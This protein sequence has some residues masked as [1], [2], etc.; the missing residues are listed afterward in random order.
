MQVTSPQGRVLH[1]LGDE[2]LLTESRSAEFLARFDSDPRIAT[3][4]LMAVPDS[5]PE[6][7]E[8]RWLR[9][10]APAGALVLVADDLT[11]LIGPFDLEDSGTW[12][13]WFTEASNQGM[14]HDWWVTSDSDIATSGILLSTASTDEVEFFDLSSSHAQFMS[15]MAQLD[16]LTITVDGSWLG[17]IESGAQVMTIAAINALARRPDV[18]EIRLVGMDEVPDY[19]QS[20]SLSGKVLLFTTDQKVPRS[21]IMWYPHQIYSA[22]EGYDQARL[23]AN[24]IVVTYLDLIQYD[25]PVY[26]KTHAGHLAYRALQRRI[27]LSAD[28]VSTIS[29]DVA[30]RLHDEVPE[31]DPA[32]IHATVLGLDHVMDQGSLETLPRGGLTSLKILLKR[33][34]QD[35]AS[36]PFILVL[37][38]SFL[39]KN[40]DFA[41]RAWQQVLAK[42]I[43][44]DLVMAGSLVTDDAGDRLASEQHTEDLSDASLGE[45]FLVGWNV[46]AASRLWLLANAAVVLYP[47]SAEGFGLPPY[48]AAA[49]GSPASFTDFGP[50]KEVSGVAGLPANW[51][52]EEYARDLV[53]LL[54]DP[55]AAQERTN[56]LQEA[57]ARHTWDGF[58]DELVN[59]FGRVA[60]MPVAPAGAL[61]GHSS[62]VVHDAVS[63]LFSTNVPGRISAN[64]VVSILIPVCDAS[65]DRLQECVESVISQSSRSWELLVVFSGMDDDESPNA[66]ESFSLAYAHDPRVQVLHQPCEGVTNALNFACETATGSYIGILDPEDL[67]DPRCVEEFG[68][69]LI[70]SP[71]VVYC[72]E[73]KFTDCGSYFDP[74]HKPDF[75]PELL[76]PHMYLCNFAVFRRD[77]VLE[78]DGFREG[79]DG[80]QD[81]DL[82]LRLLSRLKDVVHIP[83]VLYHCRVEDERRD[84]YSEGGQQGQVLDARVQ[85]D[86]LQ[87][88]FGGGE[89]VASATPG[90]NEVHPRIDEATRISVI[91]PTIG[92]D[93]GAGGRLVD[94]AVQSLIEAETRLNLEFII[95][96][97]GDMD[98][99]RPDDLRGHTLIHVDYPAE[100]FNFSEKINL[101]CSVATGEYFLLLNDD[102]EVVSPNP[103]SKMLEIAQIPEVGITG[104][105][106]SFPD[107]S[108]QHAGVLLTR[109]GPR[110]YLGQGSEEAQ[111]YFGSTK[112]PRNFFA[113]TASVMMVR[114]STYREM[115]GFDTLLAIHFN[116]IDF[117]LRVHR[118]GYRVAWTPYAQWTHLENVTI[119]AKVVNAAEEVLYRER[120]HRDFVVDPYYSPALNPHFDRL[121]EVK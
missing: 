58:A 47:T 35:P 16:H 97:A 13:T 75:S 118:A 26:H 62:K 113:V 121:Y 22:A 100:V 28:G 77:F 9:S 6:P 51:S 88:V 34:G 71:D 96:T 63:T 21:D 98:E 25:I 53:N 91:I 15:P 111:G 93:D 44:C 82:A 102:T 109:E 68:Q 103:V 105:L 52:V 43:E 95:I 107:G 46:D 24:R 3:V 32:R 30:A 92:K 60:R 76:L 79:F 50:L 11:D 65:I 20:L 54:T 36:R 106:L 17:P 86:Y 81:Y 80:A 101:G 114:A 38:N 41:I 99:V 87:S 78:I 66:V 7:T 4:S 64:S 5:S 83:K 84:P 90:I 89:V 74:F 110:H 8:G 70:T 115:N 27:A 12:L 59:F 39:H 119:A 112:M 2:S 19:A 69:V 104:C 120:W 1:V 45:F 18:S 37:G 55:D 85:L 42:G 117:C 57:V 56:A 94:T 67:L 40:R 116:D 72:D 33:F 10:T 23:F 48:E 31:L 49:L 29:V 14:W 61:G 108:I 73:D